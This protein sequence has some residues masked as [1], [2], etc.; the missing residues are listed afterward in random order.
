MDKLYLTEDELKTLN[1]KT[2]DKSED[3]FEDE[4]TLNN[5]IPC[6]ISGNCY[7]LD[8]SISCYCAFTFL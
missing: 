6:L 2:N 3:C 4:K 7:R 8:C 1:D 5:S